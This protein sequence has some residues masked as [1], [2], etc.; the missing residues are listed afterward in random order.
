[1]STQCTSPTNTNVVDTQCTCK[2]DQENASWDQSEQIDYPDAP[3][4]SLCSTAPVHYQA[5]L[6]ATEYEVQNNHSVQRSGEHHQDPPDVRQSTKPS[7]ESV[8]PVGDPQGSVQPHEP[9]CDYGYETESSWLPDFQDYGEHH[10]DRPMNRLDN[11]LSPKRQYRSISTPPE[12]LFS[13]EHHQD[14]P[15]KEW[16]STVAFTTNDVPDT[17]ESTQGE[18]S[19]PYVTELIHHLSLHYDHQSRPSRPHKVSESGEHHQDPPD[20]DY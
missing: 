15:A 12:V 8:P 17:S 3:S 10:Q 2:L 7:S 13:G 6:L 16:R 14:R 11:Q 9:S 4:D 5:R 20:V 19:W 1:M 18:Y